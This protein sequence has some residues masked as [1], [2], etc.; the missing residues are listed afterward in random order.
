MESSPEE[1]EAADRGCCKEWGLRTQ[2][3]P[4]VSWAETTTARGTREAKAQVS[5]KVLASDAWPP[6]GE[7]VTLDE[8]LNLSE[9][10]FFPLKA[11]VFAM[12]TPQPVARRLK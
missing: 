5:D 11:G 4:G 1:E 2:G 12:P 7:C 9:L 6:P 3:P 8:G 10:C